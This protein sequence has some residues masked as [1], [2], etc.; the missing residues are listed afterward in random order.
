MERDAAGSEIDDAGALELW[1]LKAN[2]S[3]PD[4]ST[5][6]ALELRQLLGEV[7]GLLPARL[8][9][10]MRAQLRFRLGG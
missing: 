1:V 4:L 5:P 8:P 10:E 6:A 3:Q 2:R 7:E 9:G